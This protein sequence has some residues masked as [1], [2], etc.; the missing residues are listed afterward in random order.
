MTKARNGKQFPKYG[1]QLNPG[2]NRAIGV[3]EGP[4]IYT[5]EAK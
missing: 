3:R 1:I 5:G 2:G 4:M